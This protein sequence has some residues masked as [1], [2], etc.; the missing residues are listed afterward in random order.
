[1]KEP[2]VVLSEDSPLLTQSSQPVVLIK[3]YKRRWWILF[4]YA[5]ISALQNTFWLTY[6][7]STSLRESHGYLLREDLVDKTLY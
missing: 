3:T 4:L 7:T 1:M 5:L 2:D 6:N